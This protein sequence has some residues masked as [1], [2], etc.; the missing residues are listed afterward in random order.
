MAGHPRSPRRPDR[1]ASSSGLFFHHNFVLLQDNFRRTGFFRARNCCCFRDA[2]RD[3]LKSFGRNSAGTAGEPA[4]EL[5]GNGTGTCLV[6]SGELRVVRLR[7]WPEGRE[8][9]CRN[10]LGTARELFTAIP[11]GALQ[12][13]RENIAGTSGAALTALQGVRVNFHG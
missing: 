5:S 6:I 12:S 1:A 8:A 3:L 13:L 10:F 4:R 11:A 9:F 2:L 7:A